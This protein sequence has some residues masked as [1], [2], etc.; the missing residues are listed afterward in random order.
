MWKLLDSESE[1]M[2]IVDSLEH[3]AE[4]IQY[5]KTN[6]VPCIVPF[7]V[8]EVTFDSPKR[9]CHANVLCLIFGNYA[10][11][12]VKISLAVVVVVVVVVSQEVI[13]S[14]ANV[15]KFDSPF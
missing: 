11:P 5:L 9:K 10:Q 6:K 14:S 12:W 4:P 7:S 13:V 1:I 3:T 2:S 15:V 8:P